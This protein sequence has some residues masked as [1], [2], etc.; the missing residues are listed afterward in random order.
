MT[1]KN[2]F[3][4]AKI[5]FMFFLVVGHVFYGQV[6]FAAASC[7]CVMS[8]ASKIVSA[9]NAMQGAIIG[10]LGIIVGQ[11][12][13]PGTDK[14]ITQVI[15]DFQASSTQ[16]SLNLA[17]HI[18]NVLDAHKNELISYFQQQEQYRAADSVA[19][20]YGTVSS[21]DCS[22]NNLY[23]TSDNALASLSAYKTAGGNK[24]YSQASSSGKSMASIYKNIYNSHKE[25]PRGV[26]AGVV[27]R[28]GCNAQYGEETAYSEELPVVSSYECG[29]SGVS[30]TIPS[31]DAEKASSYVS[32]LVIPKSY[33][34]LPPHERK[35]NY[36]DVYEAER[37]MV[38][39]RQSFLLTLAQDSLAM[40]Q[41]TRDI[42]GSK[43]F[44]S[45]MGID[46]PDKVSELDYLRYHVLAR[47]D[48]PLFQAYEKTR[49][50]ADLLRDIH[51][52]LTIILA[53]QMRALEL[54]EKRTIAEMQFFES[55]QNEISK[56]DLMNIRLN[57]IK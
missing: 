47:F 4:I 43:D 55:V 35:K 48:N 32:K 57:Q 1:I 27:L 6:V 19:E 38:R 2:R 37:D 49:N 21:V 3:K 17:N 12:T 44:F 25:D 36:G 7:G 28:P 52:S 50:E 33:T 18:T 9:I 23:Q 40:M 8:A 54:Q 30:L 53:M 13:D 20:Q 51:D 46:A 24:G 16:D 22:K 56:K 11:L 14:S 26:D 10:E 5:A 29:G 15:R 42:S 34:D 31:Q 45:Q 41:A 39:L